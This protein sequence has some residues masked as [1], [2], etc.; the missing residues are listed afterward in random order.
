MIDTKQAP[1][2]KMA[3][4]KKATE[5]K[6]DD[7]LFIVVWNEDKQTLYT[8]TDTAMKKASESES[9]MRMFTKRGEALKF[10]HSLKKKNA[11]SY[12]E[13]Y[14]KENKRCNRCRG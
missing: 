1:E 5:K 2:E 11:G 12:A 4:K 13:C 7:K 9:S 6:A 3:T 10:V 14:R 8:N